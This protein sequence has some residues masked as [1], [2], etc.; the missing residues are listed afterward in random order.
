MEPVATEEQVVFTEG[1]LGFRLPEVLRAFYLRAGNGGKIPEVGWG[2]PEGAG[3]AWVYGVQGGLKCEER[4]IHNIYRFLRSEGEEPTYV[5]RGVVVH[6]WPDRLLPV[7]FWGGGAGMFS[8]CLDCTLPELPV[9]F[10]EAASVTN[11]PTYPVPLT[12]IYDS[13]EAFLTAILT[14]VKPWQYVHGLV[15]AGFELADTL[16]EGQPR[17]RW[18]ALSAAATEEDMASGEETTGEEIEDPFIEDPFIEDP[19]AE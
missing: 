11:D 12:Q 16:A 19:F 4:Y 6:G 3:V 5:F 7:G 1:I 9:C 8:I 2:S 18:R 14:I 13:F 15:S 17:G 10:F